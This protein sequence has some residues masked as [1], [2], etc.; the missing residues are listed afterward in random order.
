M[1]LMPQAE[2]EVTAELVKSLLKEQLPGF[3]ELPLEPVAN[4]WEN[5]IYRLGSEWAV[6]LPRR[7]A[8][9]QAGTP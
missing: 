7:E 3:S 8:A 5:V 1:A 6:R 4:G 2:L 9:A